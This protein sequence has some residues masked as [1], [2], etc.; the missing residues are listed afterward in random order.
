VVVDSG[1]LSADL[2]RFVAF[3]SHGA[4]R[5]L[6]H[7]RTHLEDAV[8]AVDAGRPETATLAAYAMVEVSLSI[9]GLGAGGEVDFA[10][11]DVAFDPYRSLPDEEV[12]TALELAARGLTVRGHDAASAE[13][14]TSAGDDAR[15]WVTD[16]REHLRE[17]ERLLQFRGGLPD[18][19]TGM[20]LIKGLAVLRRWSG[21]LE[22]LGLPGVVP[23]HWLSK[24]GAR[25]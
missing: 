4:A 19:R 1:S 3:K 12:A 2:R 6:L 20:G 22:R 23:E 8:G 5:L 25:S 7:C 24:D 13:E 14:S 16:L 15:Q 11:E 17:T 21:P 9:R 18:I 10:R